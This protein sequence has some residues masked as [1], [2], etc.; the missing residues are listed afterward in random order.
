MSAA[1]R[2]IDPLNNSVVLTPR[3]LATP[4]SWA[5]VPTEEELLA[6][7]RARNNF[8]ADKRY[9]QLSD[10]DALAHEVQRSGGVL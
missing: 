8:K 4:E 2:H 7:D 1:G 5:L 3:S 10:H 6:A 9:F